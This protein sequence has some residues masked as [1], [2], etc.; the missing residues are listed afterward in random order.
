[1]YTAERVNRRNRTKELTGT[2]ITGLLF[3]AAPTTMGYLGW[4]QG[5]A[6]EHQA[7]SDAAKELVELKRCKKLVDTLP[8]TILLS[9]IDQESA[10]AC[11][12]P[13]DVA[14]TVSTSSPTLSKF[15]DGSLTVILQQ[16]LS[17]PARYL[18]PSLDQNTSTPKPKS[19]TQY[20]LVL[21]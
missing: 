3:L 6:V 21:F 17:L 13:T 5:A 20:F 18:M 15:E 2:F 8:P 12:I 10:E 9:Q 14:A 1:M 11:E 4:R 19:D 16:M 7:Q